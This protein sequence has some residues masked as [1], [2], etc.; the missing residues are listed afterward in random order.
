LVS[1]VWAGPDHDPHLGGPPLL[2]T[3]TTG[4][5]PFRLT[6]H[7]GDVGH[8]LVVGPT[9]AGKSVLLA[10][11]ALQWR[12]YPDAR[13]F[14]FD[15]GGSARAATLAMGGEHYGPAGDPAIAFQPLAAIAG[16]RPAP[17]TPNGSPG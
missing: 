14:R 1:A 15:K 4:A 17:G 6:L 2:M 7:A 16:R 12:R 11:L 13:V 8:S 5:T 3:R 9:G 10:L